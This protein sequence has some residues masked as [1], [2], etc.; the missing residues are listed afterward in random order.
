MSKDAKTI[1]LAA[2]HAGFKLKEAVKSFLEAKK[3]RVLDVGAHEY[4]E[5]DDY[6]V[7]MTAAAMKVAED[8]SGETKAVIFG[9]S[10]AGEAI[11][12]N[13]FPGVRAL[14]WYGG[15]KEILKLSREHNNAN[16]LSMGA[17][18]VDESTAKEAIELW[19][20][21]PFSNEERHKRRIQE[22]DNIE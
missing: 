20:S 1:I 6:P 5:D 3:F 21:T 14:V 17:R 7:Y 22:I 16:V 15:N 19:F 8:L 18:F 4:T 11:V 9:G 12:A 13:R 2:D 10:G